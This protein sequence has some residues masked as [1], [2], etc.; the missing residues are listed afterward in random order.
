VRA[1]PDAIVAG[2]DTNIA[3][4]EGQEPWRSLRA[5][6]EGHVFLITDPRI[7]NAL[8]RPGPTYNEG[9]R[10]LIERLSSLSTPTTHSG[11]SN[12]NSSNSKC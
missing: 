4:V 12:P 8:M 10:W 7:E 11:H 3:A 2:H 6:H 1:Q 5:V 9:L